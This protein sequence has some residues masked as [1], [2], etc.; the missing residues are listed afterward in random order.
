MCRV[1]FKFSLVKDARRTAHQ[2][3]SYAAGEINSLQ[4]GKAILSGSIMAAVP[5]QKLVL[6]I[7]LTA[8]TASQRARTAGK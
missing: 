1:S 8:K 7:N 3:C 5:L 6:L 2:R 4:T